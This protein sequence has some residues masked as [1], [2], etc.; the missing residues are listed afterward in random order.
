[1]L[2][3]FYLLWAC[4]NEESPSW[5]YAFLNDMVLRNFRQ[6]FI[7]GKANKQVSDTS[8]PLPEHS[9]FTSHLIEG[10]KGKAATGTWLM[11]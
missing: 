5:K 1:V 10:L 3:T 4:F 11:V 7:A 2:N 8:R 9:V 6:F